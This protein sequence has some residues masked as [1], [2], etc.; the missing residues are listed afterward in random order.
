MC[1]G[2]LHNSERIKIDGLKRVQK[3]LKPETPVKI[4]MLLE[5]TKDSL[6]RLMLQEFEIKSKSAWM[7]TY[8]EM[9]LIKKAATILIVKLVRSFTYFVALMDY[10]YIP[11]ASVPNCR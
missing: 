10:T 6:K 4:S 8:M 9:V 1:T 2:T 5:K 7:E 11:V 3:K